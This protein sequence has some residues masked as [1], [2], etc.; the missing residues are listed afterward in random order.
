MIA[1]TGL[2]ALWLAAA[3]ALVQLL[4]GAR[5]VAVAQAVMAAIAAVAMLSD[6]P[7]FYGALAAAILA[8]SASGKYLRVHA[9][10]GLCAYAALLLHWSDLT[11]AIGAICLAF[12]L[13][14]IQRRS[15][16]SRR[17]PLANVGI[18][19]V[20]IGAALMVVLAVSDRVF[21]Q[22]T[23]AVA[24]P[25]DHFKVGPWLVQFATVN[26]V[27]GPDFTAIEA[28]LRASRGSGVSLLHPQA[29]SMIAP[30]NDVS[31]PAVDT[32]WNGRLSATL[33]AAPNDGRQLRLQWQPFVTWIWLGGA[34]IALGGLIVLVGK[35]L[36]QRRR[37]ER[38]E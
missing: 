8:A 1:D 29:R 5:P 4:S 32:F 16:W 37:R 2:A 24:K 18:G 14:S 21:P 30:P 20:Q 9:G 36:R 11:I 33:T 35:M 23:V 26:P 13:F 27:V 7:N 10:L 34:L 3:L 17:A 25:G 6:I 22:Q 15:R 31:E 12:S 38:R 19:L 28:E